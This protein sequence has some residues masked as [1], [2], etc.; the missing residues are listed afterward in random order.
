MNTTS[1][2][3]F[4]KSLDIVCQQEIAK[5]ARTTSLDDAVRAWWHDASYHRVAQII[6]NAPDKRV[7]AAATALVLRQLEKLITDGFA[8]SV[9]EA[10]IAYARGKMPRAKFL[11]LVN[12]YGD[13]LGDLMDGVVKFLCPWD[14]ASAVAYGLESAA[15]T[16]IARRVPEPHR[17]AAYE[18]LADALRVL[19][20]NPLSLDADDAMTRFEAAVQQ[21]ESDLARYASNS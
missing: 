15:Y 21:L 13:S 14:V 16:L 10:W 2:N 11:D 19:F 5:L 7:R 8:A 4:V 9:Y 6:N 20:P 3:E 17:N 18:Y 12:R 1:A